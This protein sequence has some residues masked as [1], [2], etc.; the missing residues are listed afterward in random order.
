MESAGA[1]PILAAL[2]LLSVFVPW[3]AVFALRRLVWRIME[4]RVLRRKYGDVAMFRHL[5]HKGP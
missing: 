1:G 5:F 2:L 4:R 3:V